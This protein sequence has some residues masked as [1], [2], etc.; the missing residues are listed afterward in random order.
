[1]YPFECPNSQDRLPC[2]DEWVCTAQLMVCVTM[3]PPAELGQAPDIPYHEPW[4][5]TCA[6]ISD[7]A[8]NNTDGVL[9]FKF[10]A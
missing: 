5:R 10:L 3:V 2:V 4:A 1:M 6:R 8:V 9:A 7:V